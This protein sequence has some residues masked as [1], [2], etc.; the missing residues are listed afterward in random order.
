MKHAVRI[1]AFFT[2]AILSAFPVSAF[3]LEPITALLA[4]AGARSVATFRVKNDGS[5]RIAV[6]MS[7][8]TRAVDDQG[9]E[10]NQSAAELFTIYPSRLI[11]E[12]GATASVK[13]QWKGDSSLSAERCFRF[14]AEQVPVSD[15]GDAQ[16]T[17][18]KMMFKYVA[19]LY[20][21]DE[22][23]KPNL[24]ARVAGALSP[25]GLAGYEVSI[26]NKGQR[27]FILQSA[28][29]DFAAPDGQ[30]RTLTAADLGP[31]IGANYL[32]SSSRLFFVRDEKALPGTAYD[33]RLASE[34]G[35]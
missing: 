20:V 3:T 21:G 2:A 25:E 9:V 23:F 16:V 32:P 6:R 31:L 12:P 28:S 22:K 1:A 14:V 18:I 35:Y 17:G 5:A 8:L 24:A 19:S 30:I 10:S 34:G 33:A 4:P 26:A 7:A 13:I 29:V 11:V 27:H 15:A